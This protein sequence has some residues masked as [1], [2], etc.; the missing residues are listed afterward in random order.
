[1]E[2]GTTEFCRF[3]VFYLFTPSIAILNWFARWVGDTNFAR[4]KLHEN[5]YY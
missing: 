5:H 1:M 4:N 3:V 2:G